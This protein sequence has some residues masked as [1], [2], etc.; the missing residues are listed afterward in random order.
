MTM[1]WS[2]AF[3]GMPYEDFGRTESGCDCWGLIRLVLTSIK[4]LALPSYDDVSPEELSEI[5]A[6]VRRE[7][8][9][10]T[11]FPAETAREFDVSVFRRGRFDSH[12]GIMVDSRRMLHADKYAGG[13]RVERI[14][15]SRWTSQFVG[16]FRH[17][18]LI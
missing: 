17:R 1:H 5:A 15:T 3:V 4:G 16:F 11:W 6:I 14:D 10:G 12:V 7:I 13:A 18:D 8:D 9:A 2:A